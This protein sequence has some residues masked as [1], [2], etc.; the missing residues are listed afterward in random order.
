MFETILLSK[1]LNHSVNVKEFDFHIIHGYALS[2][3]L[4]KN[5]RFLCK[6]VV[7]ELKDRPYALPDWNTE[8]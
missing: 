6:F 4:H 1:M 5:R 3:N 7:N 2:T 8:F